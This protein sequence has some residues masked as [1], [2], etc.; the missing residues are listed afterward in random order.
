MYGRIESFLKF[1]TLPHVQ[2]S[3]KTDMENGT[4]FLA[5]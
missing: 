1:T 3:I 4:F 2:F 5:I